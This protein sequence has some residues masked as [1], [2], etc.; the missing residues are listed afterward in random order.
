MARRMEALMIERYLKHQQGEDIEVYFNTPL[1]DT[2]PQALPIEHADW[3]QI[4][5]LYYVDF[6]RI[7][8]GGVV[9]DQRGWT[10]AL[11]SDAKKISIMVD[12]DNICQI[13]DLER[14]VLERNGAI[15]V[16]NESPEMWEAKRNFRPD[17]LWIPV[18]NVDGFR[19]KLE[20]QEFYST[21]QT[22]TLPTKYTLEIPTWKAVDIFQWSLVLPEPLKKVDEPFYEVGYYGLPKYIF[23]KKRV[24]HFL[25]SEKIKSL[26]IGFPLTKKARNHTFIPACPQKECLSYLKQCK[27][28]LLT[29]DPD[30]DTS[31]GLILRTHECFKMGLEVLIDEEIDKNRL[32]GP[33]MQTLYNHTNWRYIRDPEDIKK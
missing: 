9:H 31:G 5:E 13:P 2:H 14:R 10:R 24:R 3:S 33:Y 17:E 23:R 4:D 25:E 11:Q 19:E 16:T 8:V 6:S 30:F 20:N 26:T 12:R 29:G 28:I 21:I 18:V 7:E 32:I 22:R 1:K 15:R 27:S